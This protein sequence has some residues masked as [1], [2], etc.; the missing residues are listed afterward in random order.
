VYERVGVIRRA[1]PPHYTPDW[2]MH[3]DAERY[4]DGLLGYAREIDGPPLPGDVALFKF[5]RTHS[6]G[7]IVVQWPRLIHAYWQIGVVWGD[8][9]LYPLRDRSIRFFTPFAEGA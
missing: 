3:R 2:H 8:A 5:G 1:A 7:T 6:H 9:T 4:I